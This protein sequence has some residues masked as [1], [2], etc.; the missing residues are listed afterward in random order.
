MPRHCRYLFVSLAAVLGVVAA[1]VTFVCWPTTPTAITVDNAA[2][3]QPGMT[4]QEVERILGGEP[5]HEIDRR[6][7]F[8]C[9]SGFLTQRDAGVAIRHARDEQWTS[10]ECRVTIHFGEDGLVCGCD[11]A[12]EPV[13]PPT[14]LERASKWLGL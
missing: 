14:L 7:R 4:I 12:T 10:E 2:E 11:I 8:R 9:A 13:L 5:R 3:I 1:E 6:T